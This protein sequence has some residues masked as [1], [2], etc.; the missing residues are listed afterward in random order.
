MSS[1]SLAFSLASADAGAGTVFSTIEFSSEAS[2]PPQPE[3]ATAVR[4]S[5][6]EIEMMLRVFFLLSDAIDY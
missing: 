5:M 6:R 4:I 1:A 2:L 3:K